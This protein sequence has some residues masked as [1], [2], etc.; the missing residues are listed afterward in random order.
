MRNIRITIQKG[1]QYPTEFHLPC[2]RTEYFEWTFCLVKCFET[3]TNAL[4]KV[5]IGLIFLKN[6]APLFMIPVIQKNY[7]EL[8]Q[9]LF[10]ET[11]KKSNITCHLFDWDVSKNDLERFCKKWN[12]NEHFSKVFLSWDMCNEKVTLCLVGEKAQVEFVKP[13]VESELQKYT[14]LPCADNTDTSTW[15][16]PVRSIIAKIFEKTKERLETEFQVK[17]S[18]KADSEIEISA[19]TND[20]AQGVFK[21]VNE[22]SKCVQDIELPDEL[23]MLLLSSEKARFFIK[24]EMRKDYG[25]EIHF[26]Q[27]NRNALDIL[28][29]FEENNFNLEGIEEKILKNLFYIPSSDRLCKVFTS[30]VGKTI[31]IE[32]LKAY[33]GKV[34]IVLDKTSKPCCV[35]T[36]DVEEKIKNSLAPF[37]FTKAIVIL[38][39]EEVWRFCHRYQVFQDIAK[40]S[41]CDYQLTEDAECRWIVEVSG[42]EAL[43]SKFCGNIEEE[44]KKI[45]TTTVLSVDVSNESMVTN[46]I[47]KWN[48]EKRCLIN[49]RS[50]KSKNSA[51]WK[52]WIKKRGTDISMIYCV[53]FNVITELQEDEFRVTV[54]PEELGG[55]IF[56][57]LS[58]T[59]FNYDKPNLIIRSPE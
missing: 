25:M 41:G 54:I 37:L 45:T 44:T 21:R 51:P 38:P 57:F 48:T 49:I 11:V 27:F 24:T 34:Q 33:G 9:Q 53:N 31:S 43:V 39:S 59:K 50:E 13:L 15:R 58:D 8:L 30:S 28:Q 29:V 26:L 46:L 3:F 19:S 22:M 20:I 7:V 12:D 23:K 4:N 18:F 1:S 40:D 32:L 42:P 5:G 47:N 6:K 52:K 14:N 56:F 10:R 55:G 17:I 35:G 36:K 16:K 2:N